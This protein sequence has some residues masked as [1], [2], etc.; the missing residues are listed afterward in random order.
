M[1][2]IKAYIDIIRLTNLLLVFISIIFLNYAITNSWIDIN[3]FLLALGICLIAAGG[4]VINDYYD[5]K[6]DVVN[7]PHLVLIDRFISR[8]QAII[9]HLI[10][11]A[12][13]LI[14]SLFLSHKIQLIFGCSALL[15]WWY[16]N[17]LK[18]LPFWGNLSIAILSSLS[19]LCVFLI[20]QLQNHTLLFF[21]LLI[22]TSTLAREIVKDIEDKEG[23]K[24]HGCRT[25]PI[26]FG[27]RKS[28]NIIRLLLILFASIVIVFPYFHFP[29]L[30]IYYY[31]I[32]FPLIIHIYIKL[33]KAD[34]P[35]DFH[36]ISNQ[37]KW[38][39]GLGI[40]SILFI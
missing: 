13:A 27:L 2:T 17:T 39:I 36:E 24:S 15:L 19:V 22:F 26:V 7:K 38:I 5:V 25:I 20:N 35:K 21:G 30:I 37:L 31:S 14:L 12:F 9:Y 40:I 29:S 8:K 1:N 11:N 10:L 34:K 18:R 32:I 33:H 16:S 23:D 4:Y 28:K 6:I 3:I